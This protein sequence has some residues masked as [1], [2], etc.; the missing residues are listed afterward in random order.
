MYYSSTR[1]ELANHNHRHFE[2]RT[3]LTSGKRRRQTGLS[4]MIELSRLT[5]GLKSSGTAVEVP[6]GGICRCLTKFWLVL[7]ARD[8][9][10]CLRGTN[11]IGD[12]S[13]KLVYTNLKSSIPLIGAKTL[14]RV[15]WS[16]D[17][18]G[19]R[20]IASARGKT[21]EWSL[22]GCFEESSTIIRPN[23]I[24]AIYP[25]GR[26]CIMSRKRDVK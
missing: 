20:G 2:S 15:V 21:L 7:A 9:S 5:I 23:F 16:L 6:V 1:T 4:R 24:I 19:W 25:P 11:S 8:L 17:S 13:N 12:T 26:S 22:C 10:E 14:M 3:F 18:C